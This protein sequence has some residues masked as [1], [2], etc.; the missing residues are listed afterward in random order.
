[1]VTSVARSKRST[2]HFLLPRVRPLADLKAAPSIRN[3]PVR[4]RSISLSRFFFSQDHRPGRLPVRQAA[5]L[6]RPCLRSRAYW[7]RA[8]R[9]WALQKNG[10]RE[11]TESQ[12]KAPGTMASRSRM[13]RL[14]APRAKLAK[15]RRR[16]QAQAVK[17]RLSREST[18]SAVEPRPQPPRGVTL[19]G[20]Q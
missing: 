20:V 6:H 19:E 5:E 18:P 3:W 11:L 12:P 10:A 7:S 17:R 9:G 8:L 4:L 15:L 13:P 14:E 2:S 1:M 16:Q